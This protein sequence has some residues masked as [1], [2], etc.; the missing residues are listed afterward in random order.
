MAHFA[1]LDSVGTVLRVIAVNNTE[2]LE[3][4][5]ESENKGIEFLHSIF[6]AD[7]LWVQ[8]SYNNSFRGRYA[9]VGM[10]YDKSLDEFLP[11]DV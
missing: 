10:R 6:G 7:T 3:D 4:G 11:I 5:I 1:E 8:T 2:L 9:G